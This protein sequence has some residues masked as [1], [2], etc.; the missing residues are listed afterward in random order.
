MA[1]GLSNT[2]QRCL[3]ELRALGPQSPE[4]RLR[5]HFRNLRR[6]D[7]SEDSLS[8]TLSMRNELRKRVSAEDSIIDLLAALEVYNSFVFGLV[9]SSFWA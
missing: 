9:S 1:V 4:Q 6:M 8:G 7:K 5:G 3:S 2:T